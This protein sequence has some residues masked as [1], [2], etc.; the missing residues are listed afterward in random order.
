MPIAPMNMTRL[1][2]A[3]DAEAPSPEAAIAR[4]FQEDPT[5]VGGH[6]GW[7]YDETLVTR[8]T[9]AWWAGKN[10]R[11]VNRYSGSAPAYRARCDQAAADGYRELKVA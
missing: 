5:L 10:V 3:I 4:L 7:N 1:R 11:I 8:K 6:S 9:K 2:R